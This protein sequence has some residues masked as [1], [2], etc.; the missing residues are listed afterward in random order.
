MGELKGL[1]EELK[2]LCEELRG[3]CVE[4]RGLYE[5]LIGW[6]GLFGKLVGLCKGLMFF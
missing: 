1:C 6:M 2:G 3:L 4:L 5:E